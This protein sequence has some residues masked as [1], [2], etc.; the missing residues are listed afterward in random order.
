M[1][2]FKNNA[3]LMLE[4]GTVFYGRSVGSNGVKVGEVVFNTAMS[5]YQE[6]IT[7]PSYASQIVVFTY[8]HI[9]NTGINSYDNESSHIWISGIVMRDFVATGSNYRM[10]KS[11]KKYI[12]ENQILAVSQI[13]TRQLTR[14]IRKHG[15]LKGCLMCGNINETLSLNLIKEFKYNNTNSK[16]INEV[17]CKKIYKYSK[18]NSPKQFFPNL[19]KEKPTHN[20]KIVVYDFGVKNSILNYLV[21]K[22]FDVNVVPSN[23]SVKTINNLKPDG[24]VFSNGPGDPREYLDIITKVKESLLIKIPILGIC[25]GHQLLALSYGAK[26]FK[27]KFGHHGANH[28]I[29][30]YKKGIVS[31]SSQ[32][33]NYAVSD[34]GLP[35][36][37]F[38]ISRSLFDNTIQGLKHKNF[39]AISFQGHPEAGPGPRD[40]NYIFDYFL[41]YIK[42]SKKDAKKN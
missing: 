29:Y 20:Y 16:L 6:I 34:D 7:D 18:K 30:D 1:E 41:E 15:S 13:D 9:G 3:L 5:G 14:H 39:Y 36:D 11:L 10:E 28:P 24:I 42:E 19:N 25:L 40:C 37:L 35:D 31:I 4:D 2:Y 17:T 22:G 38:I 26:V 32:N 12:E 27:M 23:T 8:P 21:D 33:H